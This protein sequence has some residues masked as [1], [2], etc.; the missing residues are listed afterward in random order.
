MNTIYSTYYDEKQL[1]ACKTEATA[2]DI[3]CLIY[4]MWRVKHFF[5]FN[6]CHIYIRIVQCHRLGALLKYTSSINLSI[7]DDVIKWKH[8]P[9]Y[10]PFMRW[11][12]RWPVDSPTKSSGAELRCLLWSASEQRL[13]KQ[14]WRRWFETPSRSLWCHCNYMVTL[15]MENRAWVMWRKTACYREGWL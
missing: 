3:T 9:R 10:W 15:V 6:S 5:R 14:P 4:K 2:S 12:N 8:F 11:I 13:S 7:H 1:H